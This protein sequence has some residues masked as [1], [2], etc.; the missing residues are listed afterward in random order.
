MTLL[1][2][3]H[4]W[5]RFT[6]LVTLLLIVF[7]AALISR[8]T[9]HI[10][11]INLNPPTIFTTMNKLGGDII[12]NKTLAFV[13]AQVHFSWMW[14]CFLVVITPSVHSFVYHVGQRCRKKNLDV[15]DT[16]KESM[17]FLIQSTDEVRLSIFSEICNGCSKESIF[18]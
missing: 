16:D 2:K 17:H 13:P 7:F 9:F 4:G 14:A 1:E 11:M 18:L 6:F 8:L 5:L 12:V 10:I 15:D 3:C